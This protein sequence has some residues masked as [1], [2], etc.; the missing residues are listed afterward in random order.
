MGPTKLR[1]I[2]I[3]VTT[4]WLSALITYEAS[5]RLSTRADALEIVSPLCQQMEPTAHDQCVVGFIDFYANE[6][7]HRVSQVL[8]C[9]FLAVPIVWLVGRALLRP[10]A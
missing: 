5:V 10:L 2:G 9:A 1:R 7:T 6:T 4:T 3:V 8:G